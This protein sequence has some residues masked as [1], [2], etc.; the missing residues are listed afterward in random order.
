MPVCAEAQPGGSVPAAERYVVLS[1]QISPHS[2]ATSLALLLKANVPGWG[3]T[4]EHRGACRCV[5][6]LLGGFCSAALPGLIVLLYMCHL[7]KLRFDKLP[8]KRLLLNQQKKESLPCNF[9]ESY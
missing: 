7:R 5:L 1:A 9:C 8:V 2:P 4:G 3:H 6:Q